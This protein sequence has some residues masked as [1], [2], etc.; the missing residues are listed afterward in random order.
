MSGI[1]G[2]GGGNEKLIKRSVGKPE[3]IDERTGR[4]RADNIKVDHHRQHHYQQQFISHFYGLFYLYECWFLH[5]FFGR[6]TF[7]LPVENYLCCTLV[8]RVSFIL[9]NVCTN[10]YQESTVI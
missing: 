3:V 8:L 6:P 1:G 7:L 2:G 4:R 5:L 10:Y 9:N